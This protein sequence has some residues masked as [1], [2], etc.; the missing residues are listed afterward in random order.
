MSE[1]QSTQS[2]QSEVKASDCFI[3]FWTPCS[4]FVFDVSL[5]ILEGFRTYIS[6]HRRPL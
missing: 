3:M 5:L 6:S 2:K 1:Q 4:L